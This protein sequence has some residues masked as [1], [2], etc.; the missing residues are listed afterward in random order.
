[1]RHILTDT[2]ESAATAC[3]KQSPEETVMDFL[4]IAGAYKKRAPCNFADFA[5]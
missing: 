3:E 5:D 4:D 1:M 2:F